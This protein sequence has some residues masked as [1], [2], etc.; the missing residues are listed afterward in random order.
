MS[1]RVL[2]LILLLNS[3]VINITLACIVESYSLAQA[4]VHIYLLIFTFLLCF[5]KLS[6]SHCCIVYFVGLL[7][8]ERTKLCCFLS[9][10]HTWSLMSCTKTSHA[11]LTMLWYW[12]MWSCTWTPSWLGSIH[13]LYIV[14]LTWHYESLF[15]EEGHCGNCT[16]RLK[17]SVR[18]FSKTWQFISFLASLYFSGSG[19]R[20][21][22]PLLWFWLRWFPLYQVVKVILRFS[23]EILVCNFPWGFRMTTL[24]CRKHDWILTQWWLLRLVVVTVLA[25]II[26][27][28]VVLLL[29][30]LN[31]LHIG[32]SLPN[33]V[34]LDKLVILVCSSSFITGYRSI[35]LIGQCSC[36]LSSMFI[37]ILSF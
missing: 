7:W 16:L 19:L 27:Q 2:I 9:L 17:L 4:V 18:E 21:V 15:I 29:L 1:V 6:A 5:C 30:I 12:S 26:I 14:H 35:A 3:H 37:W 8:E 13:Y 24:T 11:L 22:L 28:N 33:R 23:D 10:S 34:E 25:F 36:F 32:I 31:R 20:G